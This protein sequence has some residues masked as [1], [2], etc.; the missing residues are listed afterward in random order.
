M[1]LARRAS[2]GA[3]AHGAVR[4]GRRAGGRSHPRA[5]RASVRETNEAVPVLEVGTG[6]PLDDARAAALAMA[7]EAERLGKMTLTGPSD[8]GNPYRR[9]EFRWVT[10]RGRTLLQRERFDARQAF[11]SNHAIDDAANGDLKGATASVVIAE[12]LDAGYKHWRLEHASGGW[13]VTANVK[14]KRA[15]VSK[16]KGSKR[17][18]DGEGAT[19]ATFVV[20]PRAHDRE[21]ARMVATDDAF[22][23]YVGVVAEDGSVRAS[24]RDKYKQVEEF[25]KILNHAVDEATSANHMESGS[26]VRPLRV[27]DLGC[28]N[29]YLTFGAYSLLAIKR[30]IPTN[31]VGV[32]VKRQAREH[33]TGVA[34]DLG[35]G[36][37]MHFVE[38]TIAGAGVSFGENVSAPPDIVLALH[39]CDTATDESIVR[40]VRWGSPLALIAPCCH[41]NLQMRLKKSTVQAFPPL[42]RHGIL[43]E[44][45]GDVLT[46]A[47][48]AHILRLLGYR[49]DV[50]EFVGGEHTPR[51]TLIRA[52]RT[53]AL[54]SKE[55]W[56]EYDNMMKTWG[57]E[58]FLAE[59]L[60]GEI[61]EARARSGA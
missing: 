36:D 55:A 43:S 24:K 48:R 29:A 49:V 33:N 57:V 12:A 27:C 11:A 4:D 20:G 56:E 47:F 9:V 2:T 41:H 15:T 39:A 5:S 6:T 34:T 35:W 60:R 21:K 38:G 45:F 7:L 61:A 31:V 16:E 32:D 23:R 28:G 17:L 13:N 54:A 8:A 25:L 1:A 30:E 53:N 3:R 58:P 51:N 14:K 52:I 22:L 46:D 50:M 10:I 59:E 19:G 26:A 44:R 37:S 40:T 18:I 42:S